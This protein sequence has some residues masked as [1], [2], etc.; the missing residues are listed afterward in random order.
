MLI[1][2][3]KYSYRDVT[4][5]PAIISNID[6][7]SECV[8]F[9]KDGTLPIFTAPMDSVVDSQM[10]GEY[11]KVGVIPI[12]PRT[13]N[14]PIEIR[15]QKCREGVWIAVS[16]KEFEQYF[17]PLQG[18]VN[19]GKVLIDIANG[20]M[21]KL[22]DLVKRVKQRCG[23]GIQ[24]MVGNI[25]NPETYRE[26]V[27]A[28]ADYVRLGIGAGNGC[29]TTSNVAVH[30]PMAS[31]IAETYK[32]KRQLQASG[33]K[34]LPKIIADGGIRNYSDVI[35]ALA[36]GADYVMIGSLFSRT[37]ESPGKKVIQHTIGL[38]V[39][40]SD[41]EDLH[42]D[43]D[44]NIWTGRASD[45]ASRSIKTYYKKDVGDVGDIFV[46][47]YG[48]ASKDGQIAMNGTKTKTS[49]G[50][51]KMLPVQYSLGGWIEN[52]RDYLKSAMS[53]TGHRT[54]EEFIGGPQVVVCSPI[55]EG[56]INK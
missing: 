37:I 12:I 13:K 40:V 9:T 23:D 43:W 28:G 29:I 14:N 2:S 34:K 52:M 4:L 32:V 5:A 45:S 55:A 15:L 50:I 18:S 30:Y 25:A 36:L 51:T 24:I 17:V 53:Y 33:Y 44:R 1:E 19:E 3:L 31:L 49:E 41:F 46:K 42:Y 26:V 27:K 21:K 22:Y 20:H 8:P 6:S 16:L 56:S 35:K 54:L 47:F 10:Y 38:H 48:M 39:E 11:E 7:R